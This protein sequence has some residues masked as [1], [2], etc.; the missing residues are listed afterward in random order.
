[1]L[2]IEKILKWL[3]NYIKMVDRKI[4]LP[5][6][7]QIV[8]FLS[9]KIDNRVDG[10]KIA[11]D[12]KEKALK[13]FRS[14]IIDI[15]DPIESIESVTI[16]SCDLY[17][18]MS[19]FS[20]L[21][22]EIKFQNREQ[23][24][25]VKNMSSLITSY[26]KTIELLDNQSKNLIT[27]EENIRKNSET[28]TIKP[29]LN[30]RDALLRGQKAAIEIMNSKS[31]L[32]IKPKGIEGIAEGYEMAIRRFDRALSLL[33]VYPIITVGKTFNPKTMRAVDTANISNTNKGIVVEER[34]CGF[35]QGETMIRTPEVVVNE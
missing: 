12:W 6:M 7:Q 30:M 26:Q 3:M 25:T 19:E 33:D 13:D 27:L 9:E 18:I 31:F 5:I 24:K 20:G 10:K 28:R 35:I 8:F 23:N 34:L 15:S 29:F 11:I 14:W 2:I 21:R 4:F 16:D 1:M 32:G 22:Q 17:T